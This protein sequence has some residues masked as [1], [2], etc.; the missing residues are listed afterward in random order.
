MRPLPRLLLAV[1][2]ATLIPACGDTL[3]TNQS[4][5]TTTGGGA[6]SGLPPGALTSGTA[7]FLLNGSIL[8]NTTTG[9]AV[10]VLWQASLGGFVSGGESIEAIDYRPSNGTLYGLSNQGRLYT[11]NPQTGAMTVVNPT[12][13]MAFTGTHFGMDFNPV[14]DRLRIITDADENVRVDPDTGVLVAVDTPITPS[15]NVYSIAY[16]NSFPGAT[17]TQL[18]AI[19]AA[20][21]SLYR[22]DNPNSGVMTLVGANTVNLN[23]TGGFDISSGNQP[24]AAHTLACFRVDLFTGQNVSGFNVPSNREIVG[25]AIVP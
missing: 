22:M 4:S 2:A 11:I 19:D 7:L 16:T 15:G 5:T 18:F 23:M 24:F 13:I 25:L 10:Q 20:S 12:P 3:I 14:V 9:D 1:L 6:G 21:G 17:T 8:F